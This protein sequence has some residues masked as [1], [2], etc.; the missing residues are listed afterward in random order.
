MEMYYVNVAHDSY[1]DRSNGTKLSTMLSERS[2][3]IS[4][5]ILS[6]HRCETVGKFF[7]NLHG[8]WRRWPV[9]QQEWATFASIS[10][11]EFHYV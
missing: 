3:Q 5:S 6:S 2:D 1:C 7:A 11:E 8:N 4:G 9:T 10:A